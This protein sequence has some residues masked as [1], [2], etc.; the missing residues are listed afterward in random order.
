MVD[1][2]IRRYERKTLGYPE[3]SFVGECLS[4]CKVYI[5]ECFNINP[6]ASGCNAARCYYT[7]FPDPLGEIFE[8][9]PYARGKVPVKGDIPVWN[10]NVGNGFGHIDIFVSGDENEFTGFDQNW[11]GRQA[12]LQ[13]HDYSNV[14][15]W[16]HPKEGTMPPDD[17]QE[18]IDKLRDQLAWYEKEYPLEQQRLVDCRAERETLEGEVLALQDECKK[19]KLVH[20]DYVLLLANRLGSNNTE[21]EILDK[22]EALKSAQS[23]E[24]AKWQ[25]LLHE[26]VER[27]LARIRRA[28]STKKK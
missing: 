6:P 24:T 4:L 11:G 21:Q 26:L 19:A 25:Q 28:E 8:R 12:H 13:R 23:L 5:K 20:T 16:L 2:F 1:E 15:G 7:M 18:I 10:K 3:G 17:S 27:L 14:V 22:I 9:I